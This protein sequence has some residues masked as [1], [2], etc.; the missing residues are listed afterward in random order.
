MDLTKVW[1]RFYR[2]SICNRYIRDR[3]P[4]VRPEAEEQR[5]G[6]VRHLSRRFQTPGKLVINI[7]RTGGIGLYR[8]Y[9]HLACT[10]FVLRPLADRACIMQNITTILKADYFIFNRYIQDRQPGV[11]PEAGKQRLGQARHLSRR[12][13]TPES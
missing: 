8:R 1:S 9:R 10:F 3:Q 2:L 6:Q 5:L 13:Q 4:G 12:F 7:C 11:R